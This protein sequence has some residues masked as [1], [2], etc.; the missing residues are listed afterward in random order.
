MKT[1]V[2]LGQENGEI[3]HYIRTSDI[4]VNSLNLEVDIVMHV[5]KLDIDESKYIS[6]HFPSDDEILLTENIQT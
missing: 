2:N 1:D 6:D 3:G 4:S 5:N